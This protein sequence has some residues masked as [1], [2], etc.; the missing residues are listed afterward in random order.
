MNVHIYACMY[1]YMPVC[2]YM[3]QIYPYFTVHNF[4]VTE[5]IW[6]P[7][8]SQSATMLLGHIDSIF[9]HMCTKTQLQYLLNVIAMYMPATNMP[10]K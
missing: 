8:L 10:L 7:Y 4:D 3:Y 2:I 5:Q 9:L 1:I 6:L